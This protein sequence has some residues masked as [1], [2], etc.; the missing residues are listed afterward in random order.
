MELLH[1]N[2]AKRFGCGTPLAVGESADLTV[3]DLEE[4]YTVDPDK[5]CSMGRATPFAGTKL[6]AVCKLTMCG[7]EIVWEDKE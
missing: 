7:G 1:D 2:A 3:F 5:F 6:S 4:E